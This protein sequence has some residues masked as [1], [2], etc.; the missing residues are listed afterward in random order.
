MEDV[1]TCAY[2]RCVPNRVSEHAVR[3]VMRTALDLCGSVIHSA[4]NSIDDPRSGGATN[5]DGYVGF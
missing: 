1:N 3:Y 5:V 4:A 2:E